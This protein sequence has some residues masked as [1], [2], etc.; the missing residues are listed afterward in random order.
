MCQLS[1]YSS[2]QL[3]DGL[4]VCWVGISTS[5]LFLARS[6]QQGGG[7]STICPSD[8]SMPSINGGCE[9][10]RT[11]KSFHFSCVLS[12]NWYLELFLTF[13][14]NSGVFLPIVQKTDKCGLGLANKSIKI[15][16]PSAK[17]K[18]KSR[19]RG[20]GMSKSLQCNFN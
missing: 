13:F 9:G 2:Q 1:S 19:K 12:F 5:Q 4:L 3:G 11:E 10:V 20:K 17:R 15:V 7:L 16:K 8:Y 14:F 6:F 18:M